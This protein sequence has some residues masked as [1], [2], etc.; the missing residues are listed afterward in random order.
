MI[1]YKKI[2][3][4]LDNKEKNEN[5]KLIDYTKLSD[6]LTNDQIKDICKEAEDNNFYAISV[7]PEF[8]ATVYSFVKNEIKVSALVDFPKGASIT[9]YKLDQID[10][11]IVNGADEID[12]VLNYQLIKSD[13]K[14]EEIET[15]IRKLTE[16]CHKEGSIIKLTIEIGALNY[17]EIEKICRICIEN[18]VDYI[19][20]ST[21]KLPN[22]DSFEKKIEKVKFM[23]KILP[24]YVKIKFT[25]GVRVNE[26]IKEIKQYVDRI[27]TSTIIN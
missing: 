11:S 6:N 5:Y 4:Y 8:V 23:R 27:G 26:Q 7:L 10:K 13:D 15:E 19:S 21:G 18:N 24:E 1:V 12:V 14:T 2:F 25:G 16:Y 9:K 17:Q 3:E 20:T 22:D